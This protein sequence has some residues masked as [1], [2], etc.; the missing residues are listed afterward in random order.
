MGLETILWFSL[1]ALALRWLCPPRWIGV[2][3][4]LL[5]L[6]GIYGLQPS[7]P[8]RGLDFWL[9]TLAILLT[10]LTWSIVSRQTGE[11]NSLVHFDRELVITI[12]LLVGMPLLLAFSGRF[13]A[14]CCLTAS[15]PPAPISVTLGIGIAAALTQITYRLRSR[16]PGLPGMMIGLLLGLLIIWKMPLLT[17]Q[18]A[19]GLRRLDG[20]DPELASAFDLPWIGFSYLAFRLIHTLR[21]HQSGRLPVL[22]L[23]EFIGYALFFPALTAGPIDRVQHWSSNLSKARHLPP[24]LSTLKARLHPSASGKPLS[25]TTPIVT[26]T[27]LGFQRIGWGIFMK[28]AVADALALFALSPQNA[29]QVTS[30]GWAWVLLLAYSLRIYFDFAGYTHIALGLGRLIGFHLPEN[31]ERPYLK[32]NLTLFWNSWHITLAQ[33]FRAYYFYPLTRWLRTRPTP[34]PVWFSSLVTQLTTM[35]LIGLWHGVTVNFLIW[36]LW[37]GIGLFIHGR[38]SEWIRPH[39]VA[40]E[41]RPMLC[42]LAAGSSWFITFLFVS[43]GWV[44]FALADPAQAATVFRLLL[45]F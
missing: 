5:S 25:L 3:I 22:N 15:P 43:L 19:A 17:E 8:V 33:W 31:F 14:L 16:F 1:A 26:D 2:G 10:V 27:L 4:L 23:P 6:A 37:H 40:I 32:T 28:F 30:T 34:P 20:Q 7:S 44:W 45:N 36:G 24:G 9:P 18:M 35:A 11:R 41:S 38:Y 12:L 29:N 39:W 21:D 13:E 42:R